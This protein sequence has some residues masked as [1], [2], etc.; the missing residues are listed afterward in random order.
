MTDSP[1]DAL[2]ARVAD[3]SFFLSSALTAYQDRHRL[4]DAGLAAKLGCA[5]AG[6]TRLR[7]YRRPGAAEP[8]RTAEED[9][10]DIAGRFGIDPATLR[11]IVR[12]AAGR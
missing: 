11:R 9:V 3:D 2:A 10:V 4:D 12:E 7:L 5:V 8:E 1:L 6:L